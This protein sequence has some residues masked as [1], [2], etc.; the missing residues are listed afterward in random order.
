MIRWVVTGPAGAGKSAFAAELAGLGATVL[1]GDLLGHEILAR[2]D[3]AAAV[4]GAFGSETVTG[5]TVDRA[6][7][8]PIVFGDPAALQRLNDLTH[9]GLAELM[10]ARL[11]DLAATGCGLA[12]LEAAVYFLLP[13]PPPADLV[14]AVV[15]A[16]TI[17]RARLE[18]KGLASGTAAD[19]VGAQES[20]APLWRRADL[21]VNN[22]GAPE[23]LAAAARG[24]W[25]ERGPDSTLDTN[26]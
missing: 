14:V 10:S 25:R 20:M 19:R 5:G 24:L 23:E 17:R 4:A 12:V 18:A 13:T 7:L 1:D 6:L 26:G 9:P 8:G 21:V 3:V 16:A 22:D 11:D 15:A 2:P